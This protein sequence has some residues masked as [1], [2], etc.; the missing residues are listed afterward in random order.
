MKRVW[1]WNLFNWSIV[2]EILK[3]GKIFKGSARNLLWSIWILSF[4]SEW[5]MVI[6]YTNQ[7]IKR[8]IM[9]HSDFDDFKVCYTVFNPNYGQKNVFSNRPAI[10]RDLVSKFSI[11]FKYIIIWIFHRGL[12]GIELECS[13]IG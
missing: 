8:G 7:N 13:Y 6:I 10:L 2:K 4:A 11:H 3:K 9:I 1:A 5:L 12:H